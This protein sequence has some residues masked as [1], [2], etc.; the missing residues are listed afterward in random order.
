MA[1]RLH[2]LLIWR[3][4]SN[5]TNNHGAS[6][7]GQGNGLHRAVPLQE[8]EGINR[9]FWDSSLT[10][11]CQAN[12]AFIFVSPTRLLPELLV[13]QYHK[14]CSSR[15]FPP[16]RFSFSPAQEVTHRL[17]TPFLLLGEKDTPNQGLVSSPR[18]VLSLH[19]LSASIFYLA[20]LLLDVQERLLPCFL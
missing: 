7:T 13:R 6:L 12:A 1:D 11:D 4:H 15:L 20:G 2:A 14:I 9:G 16:H 19:R 17:R 10:L 3:Y 18:G 5:W 8:V